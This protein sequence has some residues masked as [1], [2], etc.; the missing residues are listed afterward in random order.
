M[1]FNKLGFIWKTEEEVKDV[2]NLVF[3]AWKVDN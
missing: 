3:D 2:V 1:S